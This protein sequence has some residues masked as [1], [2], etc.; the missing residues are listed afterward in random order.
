VVQI[1]STVRRP[2]SARSDFIARVLTHLE[3][4]GFDGAPRYLGRDDLDRDILSFIP[5]DVPQELGEFS[6]G[7]LKLAAELLR[8][9][10]D[11]TTDFE[12]AAGKVVCHGD[13]SPCN[14]VFLDGLPRAFIDFDEAHVGERGLDLGYAAWLWLDIGNTDLAAKFQD[15]RLKA[16]FEAYGADRTISPVA[17]VFAAQERHVASTTL[18]PAVRQWSQDCRNWARRHLS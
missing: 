13:P 9:L 10:H 14:C 6:G 3:A 16:F 7:Q 8:S 12:G 15:R 4:R 2:R 1:G 11:A 17:T 5:G 18:P